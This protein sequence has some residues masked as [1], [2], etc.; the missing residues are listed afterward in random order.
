MIFCQKLQKQGAPISFAPVPGELGQRIIKNISNE[1]WQLWMKHQTM[2]INEKHLSLADA[3]TRTYLKGEMEK[4][5]FGGDY[6]EIE[7]YVPE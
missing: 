3:E 6:D 4:F 5:L 2:L 7:G 1:A